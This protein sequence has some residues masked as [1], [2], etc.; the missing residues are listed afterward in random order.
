MKIKAISIILL[1]TLFIISF[2]NK[3]E[4]SRFSYFK[5]QHEYY[6]K[7]NQ[8]VKTL[9][10]SK[11]DRKKIALPP[12]RYY[13]RQWQL[14]MNPVLG[15]PTPENLI[16]IQDSISRLYNNQI[17]TRIPGDDID[18]PWIERGPSNVGGRTKA[19]M[20][21]PNDSSNE[22]VFAGG[23]SGG[24][25]KNTN[26]SNDTSGWQL[27]DIPENLAVT[28]ITY[29]PNNP[30]V[31][32]VGTGES[33]TFGDADGNGLWKSSDGGNSWEHVFGGISGESTFLSDAIVEINNPPSLAGDVV[34]TQANFGPELTTI[35]G[36]VVLA[37]DDSTQPTL[38][39]NPLVNGSEVNGNIVIIRR[40]DCNFV[41]KVNYAQD[42][43]AIAV[44]M[45]NNV[46]GPPITQG[47]DDP[48]ITIPSI[49]IPKN[50]GEAIIAEL[51]GSVE[52]EVTLN[53]V[54]TPISGVYLVPGE[55]HINDVVV[56]NNNNVSE[57][58]VSV[59]DSFYPI[60]S[61]STVFGTLNYGLYKSVD[62]GI[63][64]NLLDLPETNEGNPTVP[65]DLEIGQDNTLW[66]SSTYSTFY[67]DGGGRVFKSLDGNTFSEVAAYN[68][69]SRT[70]IAVSKT[71]PGVVYVL[72]NRDSDV[73]PVSMYK[74]SNAF[75]SQS[76]LNLPNDSDPSI[77]D[78]DF[79]NGQ[80]HY[81]LTIEVDPTNDNIVYVGG[82][83]LFKSIN[84]GTSWSQIS[85]WW[86]GYGH[87]YVHADQHGITFSNNGNMVFGNDGGVY[88][89]DNAG[90]DIEE[91]NNNYNVTQLYKI[92]VAPTTAFSGEMIIAGAQDNGSLL[93]SDATSG[94]NSATEV[95]G[96]DGGY[97][98]FDQDGSDKYYITNYVYN[99]S[100]VLKNLENGQERTI[101]SEDYS[102]NRNG[103][104]IA[105]QALD[106]NL[107]LLYSNYSSESTYRIRRYSNLLSGS[108]GKFNIT[109]V[110]LD[111]SPTYLEVS[112]YTSTSTTLLVGTETAKLLK[113][114]NANISSGTW[115]D[116]SDE[117]FF[118]SISDIQYGQSENEIFVTMHN[119]GVNNIW[120][121]ND[122]GNTWD[123]KDGN[124]P[125]I[126][127]KAVMQN[128]LNAD[129][130]MIGTDLGI[131]FTQNFFDDTPSW[132]QSQN[133]MKS[134]KITDIQKRND[135]RVYAATY[136]R[137]VFS[138][139]LTSSDST[140]GYNMT[141]VNEVEL[142]PNPASNY[143]HLN[144]NRPFTSYEIY[145][146]NGQLVKK[147]LLGDENTVQIN[148]TELESGVYFVNLIDENE[149]ISTKFILN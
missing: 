8:F 69:G 124:L 35:S 37:D 61:S 51:E 142:Y 57:V 119:Y 110:L 91:M 122:G 40:G 148:V 144:M 123:K 128:P 29:D 25:W 147:D 54:E 78:S 111:A 47:G 98:F 131:W 15:R 74:T 60:S 34:A 121:T 48:G 2:N 16:Y 6:L 38:A 53:P 50:Q 82:I 109:D 89:S 63:S 14:T 116:I 9:E 27:V 33:Y 36:L 87:Q 145:N 84:G 132:Y 117:Q 17:N 46:V 135:N 140:V 12:N 59:G 146:S 76:T 125:D 66:L 141:T 95:A 21:D 99:C 113:V 97:C 43:G 139:Q 4:T 26:I 18:N 134:V 138:G 44:I 103:D 114:T 52:V 65:N 24:L 92:G 22:T 127:V 112:P 105:Q 72:V 118:G 104:F 30:Q 62:G 55:T 90:A 13:E 77:S 79:T 94:I 10:L 11:S 106:S 5:K 28:S 81:N 120:Y 19:L 39:C 136:G 88:Y 86:G 115:I 71:S 64:W 80:T 42:A 1:I 49:M 133:G 83:N 101:N 108:V 67:G 93:F 85:H 70:E 100:I 149:R 130:V 31:F 96:G 3:L 32:Y 137:G 7:N 23:V 143:I 20:F 58:Y 126:P 75:S 102:T 56:R 68:G 107:N 41:D 73:T 129:Q 45:V